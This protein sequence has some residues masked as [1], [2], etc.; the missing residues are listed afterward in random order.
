M[1]KTPCQLWFSPRRSLLTLLFCFTALS[2]NTM[3]QGDIVTRE[4]T[5]T[6][7][8]VLYG[9]SESETTDL[10]V[11]GVTLPAPDSRQMEPVMTSFMAMESPQADPVP[12]PALL[13][14]LALLV[15][16]GWLVA[17]RRTRPALA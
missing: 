16:G 9:E 14:L 6:T 7:N 13:P 2:C 1:P 17:P 5:P 10:S 3:V 12:E 4:A 15:V 8:S 11:A